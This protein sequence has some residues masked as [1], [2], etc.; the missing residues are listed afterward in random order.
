MCRGLSLTGDSGQIDSVP[1]AMPGPC[2]GLGRDKGTE[3]QR[4]EMGGLGY[5]LWSFALGLSLHL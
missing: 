2:K 4:T 1:E 3:V 5:Q